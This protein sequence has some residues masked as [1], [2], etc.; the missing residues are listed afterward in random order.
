MSAL[1]LLVACSGQKR[2]QRVEELP[3]GPQ[4]NYAASS[5]YAE[6]RTSLLSNRYMAPYETVWAAARRVMQRLEQTGI[7]PKLSLDEEYGLIVLTV[8]HREEEAKT[9]FNPDP[10]RIRGWRD[11]FRVE[12]IRVTEDRTKVMVSR[13]VL[14]IPYERRCPERGTQCATPIFYEP[15]VSNEQIERWILTQI[16]DAVSKP[17]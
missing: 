8:D 6:V 3:R 14:G 15:E 9:M 17:Y 11:E 5:F 12:V 1:G 4:I 10:L 7:K 16:E 2:F 13:T